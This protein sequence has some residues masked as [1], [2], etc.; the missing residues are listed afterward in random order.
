MDLQ[1][2]CRQIS[3]SESK[4]S[5][6]RK[7]L[8]PVVP[9][10]KPSAEQLL[11]ILIR[12][13]PGRRAVRN[14]ARPDTDI[15]PCRHYRNANIGGRKSKDLVTQS[16]RYETARGDALSTSSATRSARLAARN[17]PQEIALF[18]PGNFPTRPNI[19]DSD[20]PMCAT[21]TR[22]KC[23]ETR[24][25]GGGGERKLSPWFGGEEGRVGRVTIAGVS[26]SRW[27][28]RGHRLSKRTAWR[29]VEY[30]EGGRDFHS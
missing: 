21:R 15:W 10:L 24:R 9:L 19:V 30:F 1:R 3:G 12:P 6:T 13:P 11:L 7:Q 5:K 16:C 23:G 20:S 27:T 2:L 17:D 14:G 8:S 25:Q 29:G 18:W 22:R 26:D 4:E 28:R